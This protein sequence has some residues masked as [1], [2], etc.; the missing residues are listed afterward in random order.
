MSGPGVSQ[1]TTGTVA[2]GQ[3]VQASV[4]LKAP[5]SAGTFRGE[6]MLRNA[7]NVL[8]GLGG[9]ASAPF[10]VEIKVPGTT[11]SFLN[12]MC[13]AEWRSGGSSS[14]LP[15]PGNTSD[16]NGFVVKVDK[17]VFEG[18]YQENEAA[19]WTNPQPVK[20]GYIT[21]KF[22]SITVTRGNH[23][24]TAIG[25]LNNNPTCNVRFTLSYRADG[26]DETVFKTWDEKY[27]NQFTKVDLDLSSLAGKSV[28]FILTVKANDPNNY[29]QN[30]A[31]WLL[32]RIE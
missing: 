17:P 29:T 8:F 20:D 27:D 13:S 10:W 9:D 16:A 32:P 19:L 3:S 28:S 22:P 21:G 6:W 31:F 26:G 15:C 30:Q 24:R 4:N 12:N 11:Y 18:G 25:C 5:A 23:F 2:P 7:S 14:P 1:F